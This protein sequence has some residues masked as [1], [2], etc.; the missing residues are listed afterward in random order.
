MGFIKF[1]TILT[2][3]THG[4]HPLPWA[5]PPLSSNLPSHLLTHR[6][7]K[8]KPPS[9]WNQSPMVS[10]CMEC[11]KKICLGIFLPQPWNSSS[12]ASWRHLKDQSSNR[13]RQFAPMLGIV[14][15]DWDVILRQ[16]NIKVYHFNHSELSWRPGT[17]RQLHLW[18]H[19]KD[20]SSIKVDSMRSCWQLSNENGMSYSGKK[21]S[22]KPFKTAM[23]P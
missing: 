6:A 5:I 1:E 21:T 9:L 19:L 15:W 2:S 16:G 7:K 11:S 10:S 13:G 17:A 18:I 22:F 23:A 8:C 20:Q 14:S 4:R 3:F 12:T